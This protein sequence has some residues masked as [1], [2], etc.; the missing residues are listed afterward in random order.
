MERSDPFL[1]RLEKFH[2]EP[3]KGVEPI[4]PDF[5]DDDLAP[6]TMMVRRIQQLICRE[7]KVEMRD[8]LSPSR[9]IQWVI[10]RQAGYYL[11][12]QLTML[13]LPAVGRKFR[14]DHTT[15]LH[16]VRMTAQR[17]VTDKELAQSIERIREQCK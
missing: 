9:R 15:I 11:A 7:F 3:A 5:D 2:T 16:G 4:P 12:K 8:L 13:S 1:A 10:A 14:R 6:R 17:I